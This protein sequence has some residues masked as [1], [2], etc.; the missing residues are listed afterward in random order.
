MLMDEFKEKMIVYKALKE[1][2]SKESP[3]ETAL[4]IC[5]A[6]CVRFGN[7]FLTGQVG[8]PLEKGK[9]YKAIVG[10]LRNPRAVSSNLEFTI[11]TYDAAAFDINAKYADHI[12]DKTTGGAIDINKI[13]PLRT[14]SAVGKNSTNGAE[15]TYLLSWF[16]DIQTNNE[17]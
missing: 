4:P 2:Y 1:L 10:G 5:T 11:T 12:I 8:T 17:D 13:S 16:T 9:V 6:G 14:F 15:T 3:A 7:M